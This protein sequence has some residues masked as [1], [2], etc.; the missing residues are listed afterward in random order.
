M[1]QLF[2]KRTQEEIRE[3]NPATTPVI[4][5]MGA[6][7]AHGPHLPLDTDNILAERYTALLAERTGALALPVLP[8]GQVWSLRDFPGSITVSNKTVA[9]LL[10]EVATSLYNDGF[11]LV[12]FFSAHLGNMT[13]MKDASRELYDALPDLVTLY[14]FYPNL[15][16]YANEIREGTKGHQSYIHADEIETSLML[17]L[18]PEAVDMTKAIDDPPEIPLIADFTPTPWQSFTDSAVLGEAT[19]AT[20][21]KGK[22]LV[23]RTLEDA[24]KLIETA[25]ER[26]HD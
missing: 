11:R 15:Q 5:P 23:E 25:K 13:A 20:A 18:A 1:N 3:L 8:Y 12:I 6:V 21:E 17:H 14:L 4:L 22:Y 2:A 16:T 10:V 19:L 7:E 9:K 26:L 24:V